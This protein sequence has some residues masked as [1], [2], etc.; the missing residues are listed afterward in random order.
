[1]HR[2]IARGRYYSRPNGWSGVALELVAGV[3]AWCGWLTRDEG[4]W[5][6]PWWLLVVPW[7]A[8]AV[9]AIVGLRVPKVGRPMELRWTPL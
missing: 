7:V 9:A 6:L 2:R 8:G 5:V 4:Q 3:V 1:M